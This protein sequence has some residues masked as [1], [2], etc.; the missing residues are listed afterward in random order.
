MIKIGQKWIKILLGTS[1]T[2]LALWLSFRKLDWEALGEAFSNINLFWI[3]LALVNTIFSV[4]IL[5]WRW[6]ILLQPEEKIP[7]NSLF[8]LN[9]ISQYTNII[10]P[11]RL[12]EVVRA[13]LTTK[14]YKVSGGYVI[15]TIA[16]EKILDFLI[17]VLF[18]ISIPAILAIEIEFKGYKI[19]LFFCALIAC[20]LI[21]IIIWPKILLKRISLFSRFLPTK[22]RQAFQGFFE[23]SFKAFSQFRS[24]KT[25]TTLIFLTFV[26]IGAQV[27]TNFLLF[28]AFDLNL[29]FWVGLVVLL[30]I[31]VGNIP[32]SVPGKIG[33][34]EYAVIL[35]LAAFGISKSH[36]LSYGILL[37][38]VAYLPKI[39]LGFVF[40]ATMKEFGI[41]KMRIKQEEIV[42]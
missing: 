31:Q 20:F 33:V 28:K 1:V 10:M 15:G 23:K 25:S 21:I 18:W 27:L 19:A 16:I 22:L 34:F 42:D 13:Y 32:P 38:L 26:L 29:S 17:F 40:I 8:R 41:K 11:A 35:A 30:A 9:I 4:F 7:L 3:I 24:I 39:L 36:A 2:A 37:H 5:G 14:Q 12:G 6:Q